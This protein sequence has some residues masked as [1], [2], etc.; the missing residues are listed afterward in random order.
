MAS[1]ALRPAPGSGLP[2]ILVYETTAIGRDELQTDRKRIDSPHFTVTH[3]AGQHTIADNSSQY[4]T[5]LNEERLTAARPLKHGDV[6]KLARDVR[7]EA[8]VEFAF[9]FCCPADADA[10]APPPTP[11]RAPTLAR[12]PTDAEVAA[13]AAEVASFKTSFESEHG[14][15]PNH[16]ELHSCAAYKEQRR[17][18]AARR[19]GGR[20]AASQEAVVAPAAPAPVAEAASEAASAKTDDVTD[21]CA[22][23]EGAQRVDA[24][25][26][27]VYRFN[28][29]PKECVAWLTSGADCKALGATEL[30]RWFLTEEGLSTK[31]LGSWLGGNSELQVAAL[32]AFA[33]ELDFGEMA[34]VDALR[35]FLSLFKLPGEAQMIDRIMQAF[36]DRWAAVRADATLTADVVYV[37]AFSLIMLNTDLHNPQIAPDRKM[38]REQFVR[39]NRGIGVGG[40]DLPETLLSELYAKI[41]ENEIRMEQREFI[42]AGACE[43]WL[44]KQGGKVRSWKRRWV[45]LSKSVLYYFEGEKESSPKGLVPLENVVV[46]K[47]DEKKSERP[48]AFALS[49]SEEEGAVLK[50]AKGDGKGGS[51]TQGNHTSFV[52]A[53]ESEEERR[54]WIVALRE[55]VLVTRFGAAKADESGKS[56]S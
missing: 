25:K 10:P 31:Q 15:P 18:R 1:G 4:G 49:S 47:L 9:T 3:A 23:A 19:T 28:Q 21:G 13:L 54:R 24:P 51:L 12:V 50:T 16:G 27:A 44:W 42:G 55:S 5:W 6:I 32:R 8:E 45:I 17:A 20:S 40:T 56:A 48:F 43:G 34:V 36:A 11:R 35:Y 7:R 29:N 26:G 22:L 14:R 46:R 38:T 2:T 52:I 41:K 53:A 39:N 33:G 37:L 30:A